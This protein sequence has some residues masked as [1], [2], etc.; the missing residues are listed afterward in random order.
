[1]NC[2]FLYKSNGNN[3]SY[4]GIDLF[5]IDQKDKRDEIKPNFSHIR[6]IRVFW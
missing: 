2:N 3:F 4:T 6:S 1:M 5:G